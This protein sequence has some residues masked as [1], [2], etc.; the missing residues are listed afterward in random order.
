MDPVVRAALAS[1]ARQLR[2]KLKFSQ[3]KVA[4]LSG[5]S[6]EYIGKLEPRTRTPSLTAAILVSTA[7]QEDPADTFNQV[8]SLM[9]RFKRLEGQDAEAVDI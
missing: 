1:V 4:E 9:P 3:K 5:Y 2:R 7:L 8:R 6:E